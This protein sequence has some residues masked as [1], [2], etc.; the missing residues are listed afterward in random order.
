[1]DFDQFLNASLVASFIGAAIAFVIKH[2]VLDRK[3]KE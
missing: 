1:M 3:S 2:F